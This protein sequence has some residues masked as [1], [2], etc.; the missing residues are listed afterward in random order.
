VSV[1]GA[2]SAVARPE[3]RKFLGFSIANDGSEQRIA[4]K[5]LATV[6]AAQQRPR[7]D[8]AT[9]AAQRTQSQPGR[10]CCRAQH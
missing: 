4:P 5:A 8:C 9:I 1:T 3:E 2:K 7:F 10:Y 6:A